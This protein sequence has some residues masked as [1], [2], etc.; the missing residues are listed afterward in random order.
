MNLK[1]E[2]Q[3]VALT[4]QYLIKCQIYPQ[5]P[6]LFMCLAKNIMAIQVLWEVTVTFD[7]WQPSDYKSVIVFV[8]FHQ[9]V[10][11]T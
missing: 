9:I 11:R 8:K 6:L 7:F 5:F 3:S 4:V 2:H 1:D 10:Q